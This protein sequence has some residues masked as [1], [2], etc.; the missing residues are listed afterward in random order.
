[1]RSMEF[2]TQSAFTEIMALLI[3]A[4]V[5]GLV[6]TLLRQPL[7]VSFIAS[8]LLAGP[9]ALNIVRS[10]D[11]IDLLSHIG[12]AVLLF[13]VGIKLDLKLIRS[14]GAVS[15]LTGVGQVAFTSVF[16]FG[17]GLALGLDAI[18]SLYVAVALTFSST[19][20][21]VKL[22]SDKREIDSLHG[23]I[24]LGFLIVQDLI[25]VFAMIV[26][27]AIGAR[28][29]AD[30]DGA[31][32]VIGVVISGAMLVGLVA[33]LVRY[34]A[35]PLTERLARTPELLV[36]FALA[37]A[38]TF[39]AI[40]DAAGLGKEIGGL[41]AGVSLASNPY[42]EMIAARLAPLRDFLLL[43]FF[44]ELGAGVDISHLAAHMVAAAVFSIFVLIGNP[45]IVLAIMG[46]MGYRKRTG[47]LAGLTV[48]QI[49]EFSL[50]FAA[51]GVSLGHIA[52]DV[53][54]LVTLVG[55]VTITASTYMIVYSHDIYPWFERFLGVFERK[56][57]PRERWD[58]PQSVGA[59]QDVLILGLGRFGAALGLRLKER[60]LRP[61]GVDFNPTAVR[62]WMT[63]GLDA[64]YGDATDP[65]FIAN[66][67]LG[68]LRWIVST[69]PFHRPGLSHEDSRTTLLQIIRGLGYQGRIAVTSHDSRSRDGL[70]AAGADVVLEPFQNAA[71]RAAEI[72][73]ADTEIEEQRRGGGQANAL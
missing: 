73:T 4:T 42:R 28:G 33:I 64:E 53:L 13:L 60:G 58:E 24:A 1:M 52:Q 26:L 11:Q 35:K 62:R 6:G 37:L 39:A 22:L 17:I 55:L 71:D 54:G 45:I 68:S 10:K 5:T 50:I 23:Q 21:I 8:G 63:F 31:E 48:A 67:P 56:G 72:V 3:L 7:I 20:I 25:V 14:L 69:I 44:V 36:T 12:V 9:S 66:L 59:P 65:E 40:G 34:V 32:E 38:V 30:A 18:T 41:L 16:G 43:F 2:V 27:A 57:T 49:S 47:F 15:I 70:T 51:M 29:E 61:L 46:A 19:I